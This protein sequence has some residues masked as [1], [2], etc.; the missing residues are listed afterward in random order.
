VPR[1]IWQPCFATSKLGF[2]PRLLYNIL[3]FCKIFR[4]A[5]TYVHM[6]TLKNYDYRRGTTLLHSTYVHM[7]L[8]V[9]TCT[10]FGIV[11]RFVEFASSYFFEIINGILSNLHLAWLWKRKLT[12]NPSTLTLGQLEKE[13]KIVKSLPSKTFQSGCKNSWYM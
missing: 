8:H 1:K 7:Y 4:V 6:C 11:N 10:C 9:C 5:A 12:R 3:S 2:Q 13:W